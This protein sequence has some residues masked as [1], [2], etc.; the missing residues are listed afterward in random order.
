MGTRNAQQFKT[1]QKSEVRKELQGGKIRVSIKASKR[2]GY[3]K[4]T[5]VHS[6]KFDASQGMLNTDS[7]VESP[8]LPTE[9]NNADATKDVI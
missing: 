5:D 7:D 1:S 8:N 4:D 6:S 2:K 3:L 9:S